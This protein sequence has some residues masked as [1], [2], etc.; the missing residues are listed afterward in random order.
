M[1]ILAFSVIMLA[2]L[3]DAQNV[4]FCKISNNPDEYEGKTVRTSLYFGFSTEGDVL[5]APSCPKQFISWSFASQG[6]ADWAKLQETAHRAAV[7]PPAKDFQAIFTIV[8][9]HDR[10]NYHHVTISSISD[11]VVSIDDGSKPVMEGLYPND[12]F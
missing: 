6:K 7:T 8:Y 10:K 4:D 5:Y 3:G 9:H 1:S 11:V 12:V 2:L